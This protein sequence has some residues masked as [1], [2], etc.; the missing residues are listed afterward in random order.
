LHNW[1]ETLKVAVRDDVFK[2]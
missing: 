1:V 2:P